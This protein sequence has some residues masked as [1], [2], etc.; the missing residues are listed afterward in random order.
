MTW[1]LFM[2]LSTLEDED[3]VKE[4]GRRWFLG[5][6]F[7]T[8]TLTTHLKRKE[9]R[10]RFC[11]T[12]VNLKFEAVFTSHLSFVGTSL[13]PAH[14]RHGCSRFLLFPGGLRSV[15]AGKQEELIRFSFH[16]GTR[17]LTGTYTSLWM[18]SCSHSSSGISERS[19]MAFFYEIGAKVTK[20]KNFKTETQDLCDWS[21]D[22]ETWGCVTF[23][24][25]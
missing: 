22:K 19:K 24:V 2:K 18:L 13:A 14:P 7:Q 8:F 10:C 4:A 15:F 20:Q 5:S 3:G 11:V 17:T 23:I 21:K 9:N 25:R 12:A 16:S 6:Q 1:K